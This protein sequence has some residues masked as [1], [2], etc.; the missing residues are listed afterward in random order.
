MYLLERL[1]RN[2]GFNR[3]LAIELGLLYVIEVVTSDY[4]AQ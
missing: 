3:E 2:Y 1:D 4:N